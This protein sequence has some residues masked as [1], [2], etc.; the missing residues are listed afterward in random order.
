MKQYNSNIDLSK[1]YMSQFGSAT[2]TKD[3]DN[4][5]TFGTDGTTID[6]EAYIK[7]NIKKLVAGDIITV[8]YDANVVGE[9][10]NVLFTVDPITTLLT[11]KERYSIYAINGIYKGK[12]TFIIPI[13]GYYCIAV[14]MRYNRDLIGTI[15]NVDISVKS[16]SAHTVRMIPTND[17][18]QRFTLQ[19]TATGVFE[20]RDDWSTNDGV[21]TS[22]IV[23]LTL[24]LSTKPNY[25]YQAF[26]NKMFGGAS[27]QYTVR[28]DNSSGNTVTLQFYDQTN[29]L[30]N[31]ADI[32]SD[33]YVGLLLI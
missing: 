15:K 20:M 6:K 30:V 19:S 31:I 32:P 22:N 5:Y 3:A 18:F 17:I 29:T 9:L 8:N 25:R 1:F 24:T 4:V 33:V 16:N 11:T 14:G 27:S 12:T 26:T 21:L 28:A 10:A 23:T 2:L 7:T 13:D